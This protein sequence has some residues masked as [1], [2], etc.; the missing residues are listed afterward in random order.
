MKRTETYFIT[1][2]ESVLPFRFSILAISL[3][4]SD[5]GKELNEMDNILDQISY[6]FAAYKAGC[7][8]E[9]QEITLTA[10]DFLALIDEYPAAL[11]ELGEKLIDSTKK[12]E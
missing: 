9:K 11:N 6:F 1:I 5:T 2:G 7:N 8:Y 10:D 3:F 12:K 4:K